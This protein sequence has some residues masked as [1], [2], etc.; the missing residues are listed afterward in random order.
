MSGRGNRGFTILELLLAMT[1]FLII[2]GAMFELLDLS[3]KKYNTETQVSSAYQEA[4]YAMDQII[5]DFNVSGFPPPAMFTTVPVTKPWTYAVGPVAWSP[6]YTSGADCQI[7]ACQ[8]P[9]A[10]DL[11]I[12]THLSTDTTD[13]NVS[14]IW[15]H[16]D[17]PTNT[18]FREVVTKTAGDPSSTVLAA[19]TQVPLL[20]NVMNDPGAALETQIQAQNPN[21]YPGGLPV[22]IFQYYCVSPTPAS[23]PASVPCSSAGANNAPRFITDVEITLIV[24]TPQNDLQTQQIKLVELNGRGHRSN[25]NL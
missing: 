23:G 15:Y 14:W 13:S 6:G 5:R 3:Q 7:G 9:S 8:T 18:L 19:N 4:R 11:I 25:P 16:L 12:E 10:E 21:M 20:T 17:Q 2:C 1:I 22:P 24:K